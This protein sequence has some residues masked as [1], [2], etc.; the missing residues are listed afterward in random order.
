MYISRVQ[1]GNYK[2]YLESPVLE[3]KP[4]F[5]VV[6]GKN[7]SGKTALIEALSGRIK[8]AGHRSPKT[9]PSPTSALPNSPSWVEMDL[10]VTS[11]ELIDLFLESPARFQQVNVPLPA[12]TRQFNSPGEKAEFYVDFLARA[13]ESPTFSFRARSNFYADAPPVRTF[14]RYPTFGIYAGLTG[15]NNQGT[16]SFLVAKAEPLTRTMSFQGS[17]SGTLEASDFGTIAFELLAERVYCFRA[18]RFSTGRSASGTDRML[19][20]DASNLPEVLA[21]LQANPALFSRLNRLV[22]EILDDVGGISV[23]PTSSEE[24]KILVWPPGGDAGREDLA[25]DLA[26]CG[27]GIV[28]VVSILYV[29][30]N[31]LHPQTIIIDEPQTFLHPGAI[32]KLLE[33]LKDYPK[34]Q[35]IIT[36]HSPISLS[37]TDPATITIVRKKDAESTFDAISLVD[38][39]VLRSYLAEVGA[40]LSDVFGADSVLWVEGATEELCFPKILERIGNRRLLGTVIRGIKNTGDLAGKQARLVAEV[41]NK[42]SGG[43]CLLP[44]A[45]CFVFDDENRSDKDRAALRKV[46]HDKVEFLGKRMYEN[47]LLN[48]AAIAAVAK[49]IEGFVGRERSLTE[50]DIANWLSEK[51]KDSKYGR[52][53]EGKTDQPW[54]EYVDAAKL[55]GDLFSHFSETRVQYDKVIHSVQLT[56]WLIENSPEDLREI[57][58]LLAGILDQSPLPDAAANSVQAS[59]PPELPRRRNK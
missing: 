8:P 2:S 32:R 55:L 48:P 35:F 39:A 5:N 51:R 40:R 26:E 22:R 18:E 46:C 6:V 4:G 7:N 24:Q 57:A 27:S 54:S 19:A 42:L 28:Q 11:D 20:P 56:D 30:M 1:I 34:H 47:Y 3:L 13:F 43:W 12:D 58:G 53:K 10:T 50:E 41:Y 52:P 49:A 9:L 15:G 36:T 25:F 45:I 38:A 16:G 17:G 31:A 37:S 29:A 33:T 14:P 59:K 44:P 23:Q 21:M